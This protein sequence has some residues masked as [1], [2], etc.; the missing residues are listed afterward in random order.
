[1]IPIELHWPEPQSQ[2]LG[3]KELLVPVLPRQGDLFELEKG[4]FYAVDHLVFFPE[5][6]GTCSIYVRLKK[7]D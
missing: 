7:P 6:D 3:P 4:N 5:A 2:S 1:M